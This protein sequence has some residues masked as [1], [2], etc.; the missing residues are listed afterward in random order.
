MKNRKYVGHMSTEQCN[1]NNYET[2]A[3]MQLKQIIFSISIFK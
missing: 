2:N 1:T 3:I